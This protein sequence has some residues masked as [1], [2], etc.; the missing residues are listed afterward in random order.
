MKV[1]WSLTIGKNSS[2]LEFRSIG[3][4]KPE[5][6]PYSPVDLIIWP[7][8]L[9]AHKGPDACLPSV[10]GEEMNKLI[11]HSLMFL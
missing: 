6:I 2:W 10:F 8:M 7:L 5:Y 9:I 11:T 4:A 3:Q 1:T